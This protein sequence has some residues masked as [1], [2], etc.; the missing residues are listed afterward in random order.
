MDTET[1]EY[2]GQRLETF[3]ERMDKRFEDFE[4]RIE[5][6]LEGLFQKQDGWL[7]ADF[8]K[9]NDRFNAVDHS[10]EL[11]RH[12]LRGHDRR[13]TALERKAPMAAE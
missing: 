4:E 2:L 6:K 9:M 13:I 3:E 8:E 10:L 12:D 5:K 11:I 7:K 1:R